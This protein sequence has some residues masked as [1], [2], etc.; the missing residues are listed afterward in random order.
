MLGFPAET[1]FRLAPPPLLDLALD[2]T[3]RA[4]EVALA[5]RPDY[6]QALSDVETAD[7]KLLLARRSLLPDLRL[8]ASRTRYGEGEEWEDAGRLDQDDWFVGLAADVDLNVR[9]AR[10]DVDRAALE[11][12]GRRG[13][14]EIVRRRLALEVEAAATAYRRSRAELRLGER[15]R[16]LASRRAELARALF[17]AGRA[18]ADTVSDAEADLSGADLAERSVRR[19]ASVAAYRLLHVLGTLAPVP[20]ELLPRGGAEKGQKHED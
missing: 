12:E 19:E 3:D 7:R 11:A 6:A 20:M 13:V 5:E 1:V 9:G 18:G 15:N 17:E 8:V 4:V 10:M 16:E 2:E 14:E